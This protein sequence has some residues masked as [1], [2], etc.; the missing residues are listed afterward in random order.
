MI[1]SNTGAESGFDKHFSHLKSMPVELFFL[2]E[3][4]AERCFVLVNRDRLV[5]FIKI[6]RVRAFK[7]YKRKIIKK[8]IKMILEDYK[9]CFFEE[10]LLNTGKPH[11]ITLI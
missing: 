3:R 10:T 8:I 1:T 5:L 6:S 2:A 9:L 7:S 4:H 11:H